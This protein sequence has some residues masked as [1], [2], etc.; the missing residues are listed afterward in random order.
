VTQELAYHRPDSLAEACRLLKELGPD[1]LP[2]AGGTDIIVDLRRGAIDSHQLVSL[3]NLE[4]M[5]GIRLEGEELR[6]GTLTTPAQLEASEMVRTHRPE[7]LETVGV[8]GTPQVRNRATIGGN[9]CTAA[10]CA[11]LAPLL[12]ALNARVVVAERGETRELNLGEL[13]DDHR[14]TVLEPGMLLVEVIVPITQPGEGA[15]YRTFGLRAANFITVA[16]VA[17]VVRLDEGVCREARLVL[18]A[19]APTPI[20]VSAAEKKLDGST[21]DD[22]LL[23]KVGAIASQAAAPISD[24]RGSAEHRR[25]LVSALTRQALTFARERAQ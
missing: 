3:A 14:K 6:V 8:F 7:L 17:A 10:S 9:L 4:E 16:G 13:F 20:R 15:S 19:V 25:E 23:R 5:R 12:L 2:L 22:A 18:G 24:V 21:L 11:D 1:G